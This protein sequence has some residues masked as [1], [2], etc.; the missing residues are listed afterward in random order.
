MPVSVRKWWVRRVI[1]ENER[2]QQELD[3]AKRKK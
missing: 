3:K 2:K 1:K